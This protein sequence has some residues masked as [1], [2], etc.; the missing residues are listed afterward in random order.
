MSPCAYA[1]SHS[2]SNRS[3]R[4]LSCLLNSAHCTARIGG[5]HA[6]PR[7]RQRRR[8]PAVGALDFVRRGREHGYHRRGPLQ[9]GCA[10]VGLFFVCFCVVFAWFLKPMTFRICMQS[11]NYSILC[12]LYGIQFRFFIER[13]LLHSVV[14]NLHTCFFSSTSSAL[15]IPFFSIRCLPLPPPPPPPPPPIRPSARAASRSW[16]RPAT[17]ASPTTRRAATPRRAASSRPS[18][19]RRRSSSRSAPPRCQYKTYQKIIKNQRKH[20]LR[21]NFV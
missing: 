8:A 15:A 2:P 20:P 5:F 10:G 7:R 9:H 14:L 17:T 4:H 11:C 13:T 21:V 16:S 19:L 6:V 12:L 1:L 18:R 3:F